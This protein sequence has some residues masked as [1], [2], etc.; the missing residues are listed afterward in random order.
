MYVFKLLPSRSNTVSNTLSALI[1][2]RDQCSYVLGAAA[3]ASCLRPSVFA[4]QH[5]KF[6][7]R[8]GVGFA[9][10]GSKACVLALQVDANTDFSSLRVT[11]LK[12]LLKDRGVMCPE[13]VEKSDY[14]TRVRDLFAQ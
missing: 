13:C 5:Q 2:L 3:E 4:F 12:Q 14:V 10:S 11:Q 9:S 8:D 6:A 1:S 7:C